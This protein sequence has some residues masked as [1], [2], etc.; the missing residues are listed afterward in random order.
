MSVS[1]IY[2]ATEFGVIASNGQLRRDLDFRL[3]GWEE[4]KPT[5]WP[6]PRGEL[7]VRAKNRSNAASKIFSF[8]GE[9]GGEGGEG[10]RGESRIADEEGFY[11]TGD[12]VELRGPRKI[13]IVDRK[14]SVFK[15]AHGEYISPQRYTTPPLH[16]FLSLRLSQA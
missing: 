16:S 12:I 2:G 8:E 3:V 5:D 6:F 10:G 4:Y 15:T 13:S 14:K 11:H 7:L 9:G 1:E